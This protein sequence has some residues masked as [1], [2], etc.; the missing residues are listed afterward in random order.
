MPQED[1]VQGQIDA[2]VGGAPTNQPGGQ[3]VWPV[4][5]INPNPSVN[6]PIVGY[7]GSGLVGTNNN[8][9]ENQYPL[10]EGF[11]RDIYTRMLPADRQANLQML[12]NKGWYGNGQVGDPRYDLAVIE[13]LLDESNLAGV[14]YERYLRDVV[15]R[16]PNAGGGGAP[17]R[18][19]VSNPDDLKAVFKRV[20]QE[21]IGRGFT[22]AEA[23]QAV[24][25]YQQREVAAQ[26][27][28]YGGASMVT[29]APSAD[30][31]AQGF[32]Q[33]IAPTEANAYKFLG[34][35]NKIFSA[36]GGQ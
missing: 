31:F 14:T 18:Y 4:R 13:R 8:V 30:V 35:M 23:N 10:T 25:A 3:T 17:R 19:R 12:K 36:T 22:D 16:R 26:Q 7:R 5:F 1:D 33:Q 20:A 29:E 9:V 21:T 32:A 24:M 34:V 2:I 15:S 11:V 27:A 6:M 28:L